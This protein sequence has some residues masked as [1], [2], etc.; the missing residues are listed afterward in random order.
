[1]VNL[2]LTPSLKE[3]SKNL[4]DKFKFLIS[5]F[6][7]SFVG[8]NNLCWVSLSTKFSSFALSLNQKG[9]ISFFRPLFSKK[10]LFSDNWILMPINDDYLKFSFNQ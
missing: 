7:L 4:S 8:S 3:T 9:C 2:V 5:I 6:S 1:M 10:T